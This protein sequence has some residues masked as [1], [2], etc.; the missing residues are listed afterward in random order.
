MTLLVEGSGAVTEAM[1]GKLSD[2]QREKVVQFLEGKS[3]K[4]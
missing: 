2:E 3:R 4:K 1:R